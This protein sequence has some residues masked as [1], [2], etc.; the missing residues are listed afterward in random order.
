M[1]IPLVKSCH[2]CRRVQGGPSCRQFPDCQV[3][4]RV[5]WKA[6][7]QP[8]KM[9]QDSLGGIHVAPSACDAPNPSANFG[10]TRF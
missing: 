7:P 2:N 8:P 1:T 3:G 9:P 10:K 4:F 6:M 5:G